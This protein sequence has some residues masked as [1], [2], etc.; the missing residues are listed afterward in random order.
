MT[1]ILQ[2]N[3]RNISCLTTEIGCIDWN[4]LENIIQT[5]KEESPSKKEESPSKNK[6]GP[7]NNNESPSGQNRRY[8]D[9]KGGAGIKLD[10]CNYYKL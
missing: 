5:K 2:E 1:G 6:E 10:G 4:S 9:D 8:P 3:V 7:S